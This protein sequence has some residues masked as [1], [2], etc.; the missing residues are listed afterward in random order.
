MEY[1][2]DDYKIIQGD[3]LEVMKGMADKSV[4]LVLTDPPYGMEYRSNHRKVKHKAISNDDT[5]NWLETAVSEVFR[6]LKDNSHA[7]FFCSFHNID[8]FKQELAKK[9]EVKNMLIW[10][11]N[12]TGMGDLEGDYAPQ[13]ELILFCVKGRKKLNGSRDSNI[14]K[15]K[16]TGNN[17]HPTEKP[18]DLI[19]YLIEKSSNEDDLILDPFAGSCTTLLACKQLKRRCI[20]IEKEADYVRI[21]NERLEKSA[22]SLF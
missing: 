6:V 2:S 9:F 13:Y 16:K 5:L 12:N 21:C 11:K 10:E 4:D 17:L 14:L 18:L 19:S 8:I 7:Y 20:S 1:P 15:Y 3:C 22:N